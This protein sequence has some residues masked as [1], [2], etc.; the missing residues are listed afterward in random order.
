[1][2]SAALCADEKFSFPEM[3]PDTLLLHCTLYLATLSITLGDLAKPMIMTAIQKRGPGRQFLS[4]VLLCFL[5][6]LLH[7]LQF[8]FEVLFILLEHLQILLSAGKG[9]ESVEVET[10]GRKTKIEPSKPSAPHLSL[11]P[12]LAVAR[13]LQ[14]GGDIYLALGIFY[15]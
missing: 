3:L 12:R 2:G 11:P 9:T 4:E 5:Y 10:E 14:H 6:L 7:F 8:L 15:Q 13:V 1:M